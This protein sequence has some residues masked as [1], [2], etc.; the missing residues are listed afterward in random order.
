MYTMKQMVET[1]RKAG[2]EPVPLQ[3]AALVLPFGGRILGVYPD[4][5]ANQ[6]WVNPGLRDLSS[7]R[8]FFTG[9]GWLNIGG[10]RTWISPE[11]ETH[12]ADMERYPDNIDVPR[13]VDPGAY[14]IVEVRTTSVTL[15][16]DMTVT[17][18]RSKTTLP[19]RLRKTVALMDAPPYEPSGGVAFAGYRLTTTLSLR[20]TSASPVLPCIWNLIQVP[21]GGEITVPVRQGAAPRAFIGK[22]GYSL[23]DNL[24]TCR[25]ETPASYKFSVKAS[26]SKGL[27]VYCSTAGEPASLVVRSF[28]VREDAV[29]ADFPCLD[30]GDDGYMTEVYID[31]GMYGGF[32]ELE[33]HSP[34]IAVAHGEREVRDVCET[35]AYAGPAGKIK[36]LCDAVL[37]GR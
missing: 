17:F 29:Y 10:D 27:M 36:E 13:S 30:P 23:A 16:S 21:G 3:D 1:L 5:A 28:T 31:D 8:A 7:A 25:V 34:A 37:K 9:G 22:P 19:L 33:H 35:W 12:T 6:F 26:H 18:H 4:G 11:M 20:D 24:I 32:G 2:Y 14:R 15:E